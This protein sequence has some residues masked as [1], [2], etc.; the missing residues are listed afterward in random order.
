M[1]VKWL[2]PLTQ[3]ELAQFIKGDYVLVGPDG[4]TV[5]A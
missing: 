5:T 2:V 1:M 3:E 4:S